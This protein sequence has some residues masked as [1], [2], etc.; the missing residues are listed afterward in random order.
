M[1]FKCKCILLNRWFDGNHD[2]EYK[3]YIIW[4]IDHLR[5]DEVRY[6]RLS[7]RLRDWT[8]K[9]LW[10]SPVCSCIFL[11]RKQ[12]FLISSF[13]IPR[14]RRPINVFD[15]C[16]LKHSKPIRAINKTKF[17]N[18]YLLGFRPSFLEHDR[19][20]KKTTYHLRR[21]MATVQNMRFNYRAKF[22]DVHCALEAFQI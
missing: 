18:L 16:L 10:S 3:I 7:Q 8:C 14:Q 15:V 17:L 13:Y 19:K 20:K 22:M 4:G 6:V 11:F 9:F 12:N 21:F 1:H 5:I 2:D